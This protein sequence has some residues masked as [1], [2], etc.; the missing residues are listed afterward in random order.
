MGLIKNFEE[1]AT[2]PDRKIVLEIIEEGLASI[3]PDRVFKENISLNG[4]I[5]KIK[6]ESF[7]LDLFENVFLIGFGKGS[8]KNSKLLE[9]LLGKKLTEGYVIDTSPE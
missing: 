3:Q 1:L 7:D 9:E 6:D 8:A 4:N 5:L 2:T